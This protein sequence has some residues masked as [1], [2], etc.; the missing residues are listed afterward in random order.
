MARI[1]TFDLRNRR[2]GDADDIF[3]DRQGDRDGGG[4][5]ES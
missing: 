1:E 4:K 5:S 3:V 2:I